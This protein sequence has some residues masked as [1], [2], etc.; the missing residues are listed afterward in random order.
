MA[1][2]VK[3]DEV[4]S[5]EELNGF[6]TSEDNQDLKDVNDIITN[7]ANNIETPPMILLP[8][9]NNKEE[10]DALRDKFLGH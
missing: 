9:D 8:E 7:A 5:Q 10:N 1:K 2:L 6:N 4:D 3:Q